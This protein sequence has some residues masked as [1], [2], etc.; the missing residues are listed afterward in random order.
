[1][2][3]KIVSPVLTGQ[4]STSSSKPTSAPSLKVGSAPA[5]TAPTNAAPKKGYLATL[6]RAKAAQEAAKQMGQIKHVKVEKLSRRERE[7]L[8]AEA[9]AA[10]AAEASRKGKAPIGR[11]AQGSERSRDGL[12]VV[13]KAGTVPKERK[14]VEVGYKG[15]MRPVSSQPAY[16]GTMSTGKAS[17]AGGRYGGGRPKDRGTDYARWSDLDDEDEGDEEEED[18]YDSQGSSDMEAGMD[19]IDEEELTSTKVGRKEDE[20]A[21]REENE[22]KRQKLERKKKLEQLQAAAAKKKRL[23]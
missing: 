7:R 10:A 22:L 19:E 5:G 4:P 15:T 17:S 1:M 11:A 20:A 14:P 2:K 12:P 21:L 13:G 3:P 16:R 8:Q 23:Y 9:A 18:D 6:E